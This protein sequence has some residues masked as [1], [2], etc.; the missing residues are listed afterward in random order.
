MIPCSYYYIC[1]DI[2]MKKIS[3]MIKIKLNDVRSMLLS[4]N[5]H[6]DLLLSNHCQYNV[7][8]SKG[9]IHYN[10]D[11]LDQIEEQVFHFSEHIGLYD[12]FYKESHFYSMLLFDKDLKMHNSLPM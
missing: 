11:L 7:L 4:L 2:N 8:D 1:S 6:L 9:K 5:T 3:F 12:L 10:I